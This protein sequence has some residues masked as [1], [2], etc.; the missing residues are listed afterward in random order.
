MNT[1][2]LCLLFTFAVAMMFAVMIRMDRDAKYVSYGCVEQIEI[3][4]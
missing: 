3:T 1:L 2:K 4:K